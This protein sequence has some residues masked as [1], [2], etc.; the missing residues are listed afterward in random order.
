MY[1]K[2]S[3]W[4]SKCIG[5]KLRCRR[6][7]VTVAE[8]CTGGWIAKVLTDI[9]GSSKWFERG[10][11]AYSN[12]AKQQMLGVQAATLAYYGSVSKQTVSEMVLGACK[13]ASA[14]YG[15]AVSGI[16][17][18]N[19]GTLTKPVG[20]VW[21]AITGPDR[22]IFTYLNMFSGTRSTIRGQSVIRALQVLHDQFLRNFS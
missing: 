16:A 20:T 17:G 15:I 3:Y 4:L 10:F 18:P 8:S 11:I 6:E 14:E 7:K 22:Q 13:A 1:D 2:K 21:F 5:K 19:G 12:E 9:H